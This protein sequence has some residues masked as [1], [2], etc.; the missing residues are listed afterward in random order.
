MQCLITWTKNNESQT[1][2]FAT[3]CQIN[4]MAVLKI[5]KSFLKV[6]CAKPI[7]L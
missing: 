5:G 4:H 6:I 7:T 3:I 2:P 1:F